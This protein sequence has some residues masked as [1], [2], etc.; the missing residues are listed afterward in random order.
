[1]NRDC[2]PGIV[3]FVGRPAR[4]LPAFSPTYR[5]Q[6][7]VVAAVNR[8]PHSVAAGQRIHV[9][10]VETCT[11]TVERKIGALSGDD[12]TVTSLVDI[13][14]VINAAVITSVDS[15]GGGGATS[16]LTRSGAMSKQRTAATAS[17]AADV[18]LPHPLILHQSDN[19][20]RRECAVTDEQIAR[21]Q[22]QLQLQQRR[23][24][25]RG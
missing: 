14:I 19:G 1:M 23:R 2:L 21:A 12:G 16:Y 17:A 15:H 25:R 9:Q 20:R 7:E 5:R 13:A 6:G 3:A 10:K 22:D 18:S 24:R 11:A 8:C 4:P